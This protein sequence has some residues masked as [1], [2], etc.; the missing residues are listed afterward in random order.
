MTYQPFQRFTEVVSWGVLPWHIGDVVRKLRESY[1]DAT[2]VRDGLT[3]KELA[4]KADI[5]AATLG[6][7]ERNVSNFEQ[8]T[9]AKIAIALNVTVEGLYSHLPGVAAPPATDPVDQ[10]TISRFLQLN[11][12]QRKVIRTVIDQLGFFADRLRAPA[13]DPGNHDD[14]QPQN[15]HAAPRNGP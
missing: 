13:P 3:R 10:E 5:G 1:R 8:E 14:A 12:D 11:L 2:H 6:E 4:D 9:L 15:P 7:V